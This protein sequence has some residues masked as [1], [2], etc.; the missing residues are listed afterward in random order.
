MLEGVV[1]MIVIE[2]PQTVW[3][4]CLLWSNSN[5]YIGRA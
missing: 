3:A 4:Y 1:Y 2:K 5:S